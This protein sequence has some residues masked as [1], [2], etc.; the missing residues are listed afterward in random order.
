MARYSVP[1]EILNKALEYLGTK[2]YIE[3]AGL[4][5]AIQQNSVKVEETPPLPDGLPKE[6]HKAK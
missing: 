2:P 5:Q 3:T 4:I 1:E 6:P